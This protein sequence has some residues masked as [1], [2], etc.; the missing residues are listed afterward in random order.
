MQTVKRGGLSGK[1][2]RVRKRNR[3]ARLNADRRIG[4]YIESSANAGPS[5]RFIPIRARD[6]FLPSVVFQKITSERTARKGSEVV[7]HGG[8]RPLT[9]QPNAPQRHPGPTPTTG[10]GEF[11]R[12]SDSAICF[13]EPARSNR[14]PTEARAALFGTKPAFTLR[15][16]LVGCTLGSIAASLALLVLHTATG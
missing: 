14:N 10:P 16:F 13:S 8:R 7:K 12:T 2:R 11:S 6:E 15:G 1:E 9:T 5:D 3:A 4:E